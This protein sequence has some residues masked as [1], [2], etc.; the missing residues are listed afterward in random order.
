MQPLTD[1]SDLN[2]NPD[3]KTDKTIFP[4]YLLIIFLI[5]TN[6]S[7][8]DSLIEYLS[9]LSMDLLRIFNKQLKLPLKTLIQTFSKNSDALRGLLS[10][11]VAS[12]IKKTNLFVTFNITSQENNKTVL[13]FDFDING[14]KVRERDNSFE[15]GLENILYSSFLYTLFVKGIAKTLPLDHFFVNKLESLINNLNVW[16]GKVFIF[17]TFEKSIFI[18]DSSNDLNKHTVKTITQNLSF[19]IRIDPFTIGDNSLSKV[20]NEIVV[21]NFTKVIDLQKDSTI[22]VS[23]ALDINYEPEKLRFN[24][25]PKTGTYGT[26][27][28]WNSSLYDSTLDTFKYLSDLYN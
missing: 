15:I 26:I 28:D 25:N 1:P 6:T 3:I 20:S 13:I 2:L 10:Q 27:I 14:T 5:S 7:K 18:E 21:V 16:K 8:T 11:I 17:P 4:L 19:K 22:N 9:N 12:P 23:F 24:L